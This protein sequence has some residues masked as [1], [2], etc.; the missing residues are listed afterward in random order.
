[1]GSRCCGCDSE[2]V[3]FDFVAIIWDTSVGGFV[4]RPVCNPC[5]QDPAHRTTPLKAHFHP[6]ARAGVAVA[7]AGSSDIKAE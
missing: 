3:K 1:M 6:A 7:Q 5:H 4:A 2:L